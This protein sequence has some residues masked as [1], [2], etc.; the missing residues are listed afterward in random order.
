MKRFE[1]R[2]DKG[3]HE[4]LRAESFRS[5]KSMHQ[6]LVEIIAAH[7]EKKSK[8]DTM[9]S[10]LTMENLMATHY[11]NGVNTLQFEPDDER[12]IFVKVRGIDA[13]DDEFYWDDEDNLARALAEVEESDIDISEKRHHTA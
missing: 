11:D 2:L 3:M 4:K 13:G 9:K 5:G 1:I 7:Y 6:I 10:L 8:E 12:I